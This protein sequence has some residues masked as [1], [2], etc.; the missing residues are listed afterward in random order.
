M[1]SSAARSRSATGS[2]RLWNRTRPTP[3]VDYDRCAFCQALC[4][5]IE[6]EPWEETNFS[7]KEMSGTVGER[8]PQEA[9]KAK[10]LWK[11]KAAKAAGEEYYDPTREVGIKGRNE[12]II[13]FCEEHLKDPSVALDK[14]RESEWKISIE[15]FGPSAGTNVPAI[16]Q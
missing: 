9:Q 15:G 12:T 1:I 8:K 14:A 3:L 2:W 6:G 10:A 7:Y 13:A 11:M 4:E 16:G 5:G